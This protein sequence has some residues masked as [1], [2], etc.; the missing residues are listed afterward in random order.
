MKGLELSEK[1]YKEY[2]E[3]L[4]SSFPEIA[5]YVT[6]GFVG[7]GSECFGYDDE[8]SRDH[9]FEPCFCMWM[10]REWEEKYGFGLERAYAKLP[11]EMDGFVRQK[12]SPV[13]GNRHGLLITEEFYSRFLGSESLPTKLIDW[14]RIPSYALATVTNGVVFKEGQGKFMEMRKTLLAGYPEDVRLKKIS[15]HLALMHQSGKYNFIRCIE[16]G[17]TGAAQ[18]SL[19]EFVNNAVQVIYL[20]NK[21][22]C[23]YYKWAFRGMR[24]LEK[25]SDV[26]LPLT[27]LIENNNEKEFIDYKRGIIEDVSKMILDEV[28]AQKITKATCN[29]LDTHAYSVLD[30]VKD[31]TLRNMHVMETGE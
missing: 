12:M 23:P 25:L 7:E 29:N 15:A 13:G 18:L 19:F 31:V 11:K 16:H 22:Y 17:E 24:D 9:D 28:K 6:V 21:K 10:D 26:E 1:Y 4:L 5:D 27:F 30:N 2:G 20:L 14:L 8:V 3:A